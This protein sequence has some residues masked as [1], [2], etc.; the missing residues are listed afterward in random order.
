MTRI[1]LYIAIV[2]LIGLVFGGTPWV[3]ES[4]ALFMAST[5]FLL[6]MENPPNRG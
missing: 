6:M 5:T 3:K 2:A 4:F 1:S